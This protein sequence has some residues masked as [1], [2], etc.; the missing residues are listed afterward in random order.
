LIFALNKPSLVLVGPAVRHPSLILAELVKLTHSNTSLHP[1]LIFTVMI[2]G[3]I[4][5]DYCKGV[6]QTE[7]SPVKS[8]KAYCAI[9]WKRFKTRCKFLEFTNM[10]SHTDFRLIWKSVTLHDLERCRSNGLICAQSLQ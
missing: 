10:K 6:N 2:Y 7:T 9:T 8:G 5:R 1:S 3:D 4:Y